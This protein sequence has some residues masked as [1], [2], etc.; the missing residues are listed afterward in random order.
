[1]LEVQLERFFTVWAWKW[2]I[3]HDSELGEHLGGFG[4]NANRLHHSG[5]LNGTT[6]DRNAATFIIPV[7][8]PCPRR[9]RHE[10]PD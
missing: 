5:M 7:Y 1:M 2:D 10:S 6:L 9:I 4:R 3:D 8:P